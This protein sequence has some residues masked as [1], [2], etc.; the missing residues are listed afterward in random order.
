MLR[1]TPISFLS[2]L[3]FNISSEQRKK[4]HN[5][6]QRQLRVPCTLHCSLRKTQMVVKCYCCVLLKQKHN[7]VEALSVA[8]KWIGAAS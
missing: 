2:T 6:T 5:R 1:L 3:K 4:T 8:F 7:Y